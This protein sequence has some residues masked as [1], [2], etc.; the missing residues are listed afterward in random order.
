[1]SFSV[2]SQNLR[3]QSQEWNKRATAADTV[4]GDIAAG[5]GSG[6]DFGFLAGGA[7]V[8]EMYDEWTSDMD[9]ALLDC[10]YSAKYLEAALVSTANAYDESD[11]TSA[12][13][14]SELDKMLQD[15]GYHHD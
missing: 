13:E 7:G 14:V 1:M 4:R 2:E 6:F 11:Q 9:N 15:S 10:A 12:T 8:S 3:S 5:V